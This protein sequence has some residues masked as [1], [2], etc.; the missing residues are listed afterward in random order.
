MNEKGIF[1]SLA[2][3]I[4][5]AVGA[6]IFGIPYA[7]AHVGAFWG[8]VYLIVL[9][10]SVLITTLAYA[11]VVLRTPGKHQFFGYAEKYLGKKSKILCSSILIFGIIG[12]L[13]A[14]I[15]E[16]GNFSHALFSG[17]FGGEPMLYSIAFF[18]LGAAAVYFGPGMVVRLEK[19]MVFFLI[20]V[21]SLICVM[22]LPKVDLDN[23]KGALFEVNYVL[24]YG[25]IL[26]AA[27]AAS[28]VPELKEALG[29]RKKLF[30]RVIILG[31]ALTLLMYALFSLTIVGAVGEQ[32]TASAMIGA[33]KVLGKSVLYLGA[34][35]G[36]LAMATSF[37]S[38]GLVLRD[39]FMRDLHFSKSMSWLAVF[40]PPL[41]FVL[42]RLTT[43]IQVI[44][45]VGAVLG[46]LEGIIILLLWRQSKKQGGRHPEFTI[47]LP[48]FV[49]WLLMLI[50]IV[51]FVVT[52][53]DVF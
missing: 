7:F 3:I 12:S 32:T 26:F 8:M 41:I 34:I 4:G 1:G 22:G 19:L 50:F 43:F 48:G 28:V 20:F 33:G 29:R 13:I 11:E 40:L 30:G 39:A 44:G 6:G 52:V 37:L 42:L 51:G 45:I 36:I 14:Y 25:I 9:G 17:I 10:G 24:P 2:M 5:T 23:L 15:I 21:V 46:S 53:L 18:I 35:F 38:L 31:M 16:V 47:K 49:F 27:G